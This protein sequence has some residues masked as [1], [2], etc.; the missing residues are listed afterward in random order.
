M[1]MPVLF[2]GHGSPMTIE[3]PQRLAEWQR[4][5]ES[6]PRPKAILML[7]AHWETRPLMLGAT[8]TQPLI[9]DFYGFPAEYYQL[10]YAA[11]GAP[12]LA[13]RVR[14]LLAGAEMPFAER[15][16]RGWDHGTWIPLLGLYPQAD[17]PLL[18]ISLP[19][20]DEQ[21]LMRLGATLAPLRDEGVLIITSGLLTHNLREWTPEGVVAQWAREFDLWLADRLEARQWQA[22]CQWRTA[23]G[24]SKSVP[25]PDHLLPLFVAM[26]ASDDGERVTFP[27]TGF[28]FGSFSHR[29]VQ[30]G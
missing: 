20:A 26:G 10:S 5:G 30:F 22:L 28:E 29:S 19:S 14:R 7:S 12:E 17:I 2:V 13:S 21:E 11:P 15:P 24:A 18:Q 8:T 16:E 4:W 3:Q 9:Y 27:V 23:P 1:R 25:T 6:L